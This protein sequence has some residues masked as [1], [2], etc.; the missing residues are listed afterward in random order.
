M[1]WN[2]VMLD[3]AGRIAS[4]DARETTEQTITTRADGIDVVEL[5]KQFANR[6]RKGTSIGIA[7]PPQTV[8]GSLGGSPV[9]LI[10]SSP[11]LRGRKVLG[12][13]VPYDKV[14]RTGANS[15]SILALDKDIEIGGKLV[16]AGTYSIWTLPTR[17]G[18]QLVV[19]QQRGQWGTEYHPEQDLVRVP[20]TVS[21]VAT[22]REDFAISLDGS[23]RTA[24]LKIEWDTFVW[25]VPVAAK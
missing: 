2:H 5:A 22:P 10:Y 21:T 24:V 20:M 16:P 15:A 9:V 4:V 25:S 11:R 1:A 7:S 12:N 3:A 14:W 19:N 8:R 23:G 18:V 6:D 13:V 17:D